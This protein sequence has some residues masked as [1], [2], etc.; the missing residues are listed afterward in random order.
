MANQAVLRNLSFVAFC[1]RRGNSKSKTKKEKAEI[2]GAGGRYASCCRTFLFNLQNPVE[3]F[4]GG[5]S[6]GSEKLIF[7]CFFIHYVYSS[8]AWE[9]GRTNPLCRSMMED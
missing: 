2:T 9:G 6:S 8:D 7:C 3:T 1:S 4:N 5:I